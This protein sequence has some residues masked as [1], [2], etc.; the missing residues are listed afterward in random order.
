MAWALRQ[1]AETLTSSAGGTASLA[2]S[3]NIQGG[4]LLVMMATVRAT[5]ATFTT[6][7]DTQSASWN[8]AISVNSKN[9]SIGVFWTTAVASAADTCRLSFPPSACGFMIAEWTP[10]TANFTSDGIGA[11]YNQN[12]ST[13]TMIHPTYTCNSSDALVINVVQA[14][15]AVTLTSFNSPW[16]TGVINASSTSCGW[17]Y[18]ADVSG[19]VTT[20]VTMPSSKGYAS[21]IQ[22]FRP[23]VIPATFSVSDPEITRTPGI[24]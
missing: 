3:S 1:H 6:P 21:V 24:H 10:V 13:T 22:A 17:A 14:A 20:N 19:M 7:S 15:G 16:T 12:T 5:A 2:F 4:S 18:V 23:S 8:T 11:A 9:S